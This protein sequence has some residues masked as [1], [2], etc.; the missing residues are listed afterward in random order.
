MNQLQ[1]TLLISYLLMT[2]YFLINWLKFSLLNPTSTPED[3]FLSFVMLLI[4]TIFWPLSI[5]MSLWEIFNK[6]KLELRTMIPV[7]FAIFAFSLSYYLT[8]LY[9]RGFCYNDLFCSFPS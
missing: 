6:R 8:Y 7:I 2:C 5:M 4:T 3:K 9:E 1:L